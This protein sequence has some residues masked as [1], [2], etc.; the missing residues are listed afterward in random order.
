MQLFMFFVFA[1]LVIPTV[2]SKEV[3]P[4]DSTNIEILEV[5]HTGSYSPSY[6]IF[7]R[8]EF[9]NS[10]QTLSDILSSINGIQIRQI[11]GLGNPVAISIRGSNSKQV[12]FYIDGQLVNDSQFGGFDLN[13]IPTEQIQS[14]EISK[15]Q[16]IGTGATPIGGVVRINTYNPD[17]SQKKLSAVVGSFGHTELNATVNTIFDQHTL[18]LGA[19]TL[20]TNNNYQ[21]LVPQTFNNPSISEKQALLNNGYSKNTLYINDNIKFENNRVRIHGQYSDQTKE[22]PNYR[23]NSPETTSN[24][25]TKTWRLGYL[26]T[27]HDIH[28]YVPSIE[29]DSY[30]QDKSEI[31]LD[32]PNG[33]SE[34]SY[35]Y[36]SDKKHV[37]V[38]PT[39]IW[40]SYTFTPFIT[41]TD[42]A[43][44]SEQFINDQAN[45]CNGISECDIKAQLQQT[46]YGTR[47]EWQGNTLPINIY[48]L[49]NKLH[50][51]SS[52]EPLKSTTA[53][54]LYA[55]DQFDTHELGATYQWHE[56]VAEFVFSKGVRT[57]TLFELYGNRGAFKGNANLLPE[58]S[59]TRAINFAYKGKTLV[60]NASS[61]IKKQEN[62]IVAIFNSSNVG[63]YTNVSEATL[64]GLELQTNY[65]FNTQWLFALQGTFIHSNTHSIFSAFDDKK[66][67]GV[68]HKQ[69]G[70]ALTYQ[71]NNQWSVSLNH[72]IDRELYFNRSNKFQSE[73]NRGNGTPADREVTD[74]TF[75]WS[76]SQHNLNLTFSNLFNTEY[77]DLA[78]RPAHG[79]SI[80]LKYSLKGI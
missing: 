43:F 75:N 64:K 41:L 7:Q 33:V 56:V 67:P 46:S 38:K 63:S 31:Y 18:T 68:Y 49:Y 80:Q 14:I 66:L 78:N 12:Q 11:S 51:K 62:S 36:N 39:V 6:K 28:A 34:Q 20:N 72:K 76:H 42:H 77:Q 29:L 17:S 8:H 69:Y 1:L 65:K 3:A 54:T 48:G 37:S 53:Q 25:A 4:S 73:K 74:L 32:A 16:A 19:Q 27:L 70:A 55:N 61:Y 5:E 79:R 26:H 10:A 59:K 50:N 23:N 2:S 13:Q 58:R 24:L 71:M 52:N 30:Y 35:H 60:L 15:S 47:I 44:Q 40:D 45:P 57:P 21:Y 9:I 22:L